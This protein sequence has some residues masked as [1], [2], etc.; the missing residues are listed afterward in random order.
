M[1]ISYAHAVFGK[2]ERRAVADVLKTPQI[3]AGKCADE[4]ENK[5]AALYDKKFGLL[6]NSGSSANLLALA[7]LRLPKGSEVITPV[8]TFATVVA[9]IVQNN[10]VPVFVDVEPDTYIINIDK[11][12]RMISRKT[13]VLMIPSLF[14][15]IPDFRRL[16]RIAQKHKLILIEDSCD[17]LGAKIGKAST[18]KYSDISTTSF[19]AAHIITAAGNGGMVCFNN[20]KWHEEAR[21]MSGWGR[22]SALNESE[23]IA[24]RYRSKLDGMPYDAKFIFSHIGYNLRTTDI[25]AAFGLA[26]LK[27]LGR[28]EHTRRTNFSRLQAFFRPYE[29]YFVLPRQPKDVETS[30]MAFPLTIK[31][32]A[33]FTRFELISF[34]E[35]HNIQTRPIF[36]GNVLRQPGF[37]GIEHRAT[38]EGYPQADFIMEH[39]FVVGCH[40]GLGAKEISYMEGVFREF[41]SAR[42][43]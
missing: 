9:P 25:T 3:V 27:K 2:E 10:L 21:I 31:K 30:W 33:P 35:A 29:R 26:Q 13:K 5:I 14:G 37:K 34:L 6:V 41:L 11:I 24:I 28:F 42:T 40:H 38:K 23:D 36:T 16:K 39:G 20:P 22:R 43:A 15:S 19:Y 4:F 12:E 17:T 32:G 7:S 8:L 1:R 18:G